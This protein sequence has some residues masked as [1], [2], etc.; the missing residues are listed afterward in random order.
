M[1]YIK[2][3]SLK[4]DLYDAQDAAKLADSEW[5]AALD[6]LGIDRY[7]RAAKGVAGSALRALY[8]AKIAS[9]NKVHELT[10]TMS[11]FQDVDQIQRP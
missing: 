5:Q 9:D 10:E 4:N 1:A 8:D 11:R 3:T 2:F 6:E 7:S